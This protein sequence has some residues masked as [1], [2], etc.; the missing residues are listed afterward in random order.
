T[1]ERVRCRQWHTL[2]ERILRYS[3]PY[4]IVGNFNDILD[5]SEKAWGNPRNERSMAAFGEFL[6]NSMLLDL[7]FDGYP[8]TWQNRRESGLIQERL[9]RGL[10]SEKWLELY[11]KAR[12]PTFDGGHVR[13]L[14]KE[15][16]EALMEEEMFWKQKSRAQWLNEGE[17]NTIFFHSKMAHIFVTYSPLVTLQ[18]YQKLWGVWSHA[19]LRQ[20]GP[21]FYYRVDEREAT[22]L[23]HTINCYE[24]VSGQCLN[25]DKS[26]I[27]YS[28]TCPGRLRNQMEAILK[29]SSWNEFGRYLG[30]T[31]NFGASKKKSLTMCGGSWIAGY[32]DGQSN[33]CH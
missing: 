31:T 12:A 8:F 29:V 1:N 19:S 22:C 9:D 33:S 6:S 32:M 17:K 11:P 15:L 7:G 14:E 30:I 4:I 5:S 2:N 20:R 21:A 24:A 26:S 25:F 10:A 27:Y 3:E 13:A 28:R 16:K 18:V 23:L